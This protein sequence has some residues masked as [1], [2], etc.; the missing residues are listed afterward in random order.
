MA[1]S[2]DLLFNPNI[3]RSQCSYY[4][5][6]TQD[7]TNLP[8]AFIVCIA[9]PHHHLAMV[10]QRYLATVPID[11]VMS[12][13]QELDEGSRSV[14]ETCIRSNKAQCLTAGEESSFKCKKLK[15]H[16]GMQNI[17]LL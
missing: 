14:V 6:S 13:I 15:D 2:L 3:V 10:V 1:A 16:V 7:T 8:V 9:R 11:V 4:V 12:A 5:Q 17:A